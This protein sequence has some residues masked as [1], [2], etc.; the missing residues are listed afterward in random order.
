MTTELEFIPV[1]VEVVSWGPEYPTRHWAGF[2]AHGGT[3]VLTRLRRGELTLKGGRFRRMTDQVYSHHVP[4]M[5]P[6]KW[7]YGPE[8]DERGLNGIFDCIARET[9][10]RWSI[11]FVEKQFKAEVVGLPLQ[12]DTMELKWPH[13]VFTFEDAVDA[14]KVKLMEG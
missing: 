9:H 2:R 10:G 5:I 13:P 7:G 3:V 14:V 8:C 1:P 4:F 12:F 11:R 6:L